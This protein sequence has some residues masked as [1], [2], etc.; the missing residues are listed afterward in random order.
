MFRC[1]ARSLKRSILP[2]YRR[3]IAE[4]CTHGVCVRCLA[5]SLKRSTRRELPAHSSCR[6]TPTRRRRHARIAHS[7]ASLRMSH[8]QTAL[9]RS[10]LA[11]STLALCVSAR[12]RP[13][14]CTCAAPST[15]CR[16]SCCGLVVVVAVLLLWMC[17]CCGRA[18]VVA[19]L[20]WAQGADAGAVVVAVHV[21]RD[22]MRWV[23]CRVHV[24]IVAFAF[25]LVV[26][27]R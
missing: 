26:P 3:D 7:H 1:L 6:P 19:V 16:R 13:A 23:C 5:R 15:T 20:L 14:R 2:R 27:R 9:S 25:F 21:A 10:L 18:V 22:G 11:L 24:T 17:C 12:R 4:I 8:A